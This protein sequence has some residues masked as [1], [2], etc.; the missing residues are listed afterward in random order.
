MIGVSVNA[1]SKI[2]LKLLSDDCTQSATVTVQGSRI[3]HGVREYIS[4][5]ATSTKT[6]ATCER[7]AS[8]AG[9]AAV[10]AAQYYI[11]DMLDNLPPCVEP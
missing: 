4:Y 8:L 9:Y 11:N 5:T 3:C 7:A 10:A 6:A 1:E 2:P